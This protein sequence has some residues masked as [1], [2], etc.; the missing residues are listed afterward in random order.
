VKYKVGDR[1]R[2]WHDL[3]KDPILGFTGTISYIKDDGDS[4]LVYFDEENEIFHN[5]LEKDPSIRRYYWLPSYFIE[6]IVSDNKLNRVLYPELTP[7]GKGN[8]L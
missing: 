3:L 8:L 2:Y 1:V 5:G 6:P 7:D 4:I